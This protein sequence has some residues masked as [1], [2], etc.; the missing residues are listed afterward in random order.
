MIE[1]RN[2]AV[3]DFGVKATPTIFVNDEKLG[4]STLESLTKAI[5]AAL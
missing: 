1:G 2:K 5:E 3:K 4:D